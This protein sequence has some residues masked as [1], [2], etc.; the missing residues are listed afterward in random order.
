MALGWLVKQTNSWVRD[1]RKAIKTSFGSGWIV[2]NDRANMRLIVCN[3]IEERTSVSLP[4][5]WKESQWQEATQFI[6]VGADA[7]KANNGLISI[8]TTLR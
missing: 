3:K 6:K 2:E 7:Y 8:R 5:P 4:Y 1:F